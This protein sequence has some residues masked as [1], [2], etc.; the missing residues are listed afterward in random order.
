MKKT[1]KNILFMLCTVSFFT[2]GMVCI[3]RKAALILISKQKELE[4]NKKLLGILSD[5]FEKKQQGKNITCFLEKNRFHS[6]AIYG[7]G[8][9]GKF[10]EKELRGQIEIFYGIDKRNI[11]A[12]YP[13]YRLEDDLP[14][15]DLVI[16]T[17]VYEFEDIEEELKKKMDCPIYSLEDIIY[18]ME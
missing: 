5:W 12:E 9:L 8:N 10:L 1:E 3:L 11:S 14:K 6:I 18:F 7:L 17:A 15:V 13:V 4:K 2:L 16:V